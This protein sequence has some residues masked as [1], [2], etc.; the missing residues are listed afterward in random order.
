MTCVY[1][2]KVPPEVVLAWCRFATKWFQP[3]N[4]AV[5]LSSSLMPDRIRETFTSLLV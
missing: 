2:L 1:L 3:H 4:P 5:Q